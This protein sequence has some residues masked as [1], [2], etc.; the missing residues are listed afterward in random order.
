MD[1]PAEIARRETRLEAL[2][3]AKRKIE[4][5]AQERFERE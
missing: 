4:E 1:V 2:A 5:R 3:E